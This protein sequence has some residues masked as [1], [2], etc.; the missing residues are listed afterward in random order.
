MSLRPAKSVCLALLSLLPSA[1][2]NQLEAIDETEGGGGG[3]GIPPAVRQAFTESCGK[4]GCH[5]DGGI[6]PVLAG[7]KLDDI[8]TGQSSSGPLV[9]LGDTANS[10]LAVKMLPDSV[11]S[12][13]GI[14]RNGLRM[15][16]DGD[17]A[18]PNNQIIL[19]W[20]AGA[21]FPADGGGTT[22]DGTTGGDTD[23]GSTGDPSAP[24]F[25]NVQKIFN[26]S[27]GCHLIPA[28][29]ANGNLSLVE[30][31]AYANIVDVKSPTVAIDLV[32]PGDPTNSY[33]LR[34]VDGTFADVPG[35]AGTMMP[36]TAMI[37]ADDLM[38][39]EEWIAAGALDN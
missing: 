12:A 17:F 35:G 11:L 34:K 22:G 16:L 10:Y 3:G 25:A 36:P 5:N 15:P 14:T 21:E 19:A 2:C 20:I 31:S 23:G 39:L 28:S 30:G 24:T 6:A 7:P 32:E 13:L 1:A 9:T 33:L 4:G 8:L 37:A 38:L 27:C 18:N 26:A 29:G